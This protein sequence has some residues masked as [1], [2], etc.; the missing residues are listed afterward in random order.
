MLSNMA[1]RIIV[2]PV[3][4]GVVILSIDLSLS[5]KIIVNSTMLVASLSLQL[6]KL[7]VDGQVGF[8]A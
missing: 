6:S 8:S 3:E 5:A 1:E 2:R 7:H 4:R